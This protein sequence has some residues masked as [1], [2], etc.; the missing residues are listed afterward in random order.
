[1]PKRV[2]KTGSEL[3]KVGNN[4]FEWNVFRYLQDG[5]Q[6][7]RRI[8]ISEGLFKSH[9]LLVLNGDWSKANEIRIV[10]GDEASLET[11]EAS[12]S[13]LQLAMP[14]VANYAYC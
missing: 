14:L 11:R 13:E 6:F 2:S 10:V 8:D 3:F 9:A 1:M 4:D 7:G 5:C 12:Q